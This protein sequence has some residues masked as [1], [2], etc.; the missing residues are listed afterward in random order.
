MSTSIDS[1]KRDTGLIS[2]EELKACL[3]LML[4]LL[5]MMMM[6]NKDDV[7]DNGK[8]YDDDDGDDVDDSDD[9][10]DNDD[11]TAPSMVPLTNNFIFNKQSALITVGNSVIV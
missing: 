11:K 9:N 8:D 4:L 7:N 5:M 10:N 2:L 6:M 1:L 3:L